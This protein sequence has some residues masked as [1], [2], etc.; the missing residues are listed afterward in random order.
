MPSNHACADPSRRSVSSTPTEDASASIAGA[1]QGI[2]DATKCTPLGRAHKWLVAQRTIHVQ[3]TSRTSDGFVADG[4]DRSLL[5]SHLPLRP[6]CL[7]AGRTRLKN[8]R[9]RQRRAIRI[10]AWDLVEWIIT[11]CG[12]FTVGAPKS[13]TSLR[14]AFGVWTVSVSTA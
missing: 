9:R 1:L 13:A 8:S 10:A 6:L 7:L 3:H 12:F 5:P 2:S 14:R 11:V 4:P